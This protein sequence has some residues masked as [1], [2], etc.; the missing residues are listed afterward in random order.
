MKK[1]SY[2]LLIIGSSYLGYKIFKKYQSRVNFLKD[3]SDS[4]KPDMERIA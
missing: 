1:I 3:A 4:L 2:L